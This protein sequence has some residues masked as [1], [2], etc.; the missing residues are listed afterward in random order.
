MLNIA[1]E[2]ELVTTDFD[3]LIEYLEKVIGEQ[4]EKHRNSPHT[5]SETSEE[6]YERAMKGI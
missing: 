4:Q 5:T 1:N 2:T 3:A 6:A